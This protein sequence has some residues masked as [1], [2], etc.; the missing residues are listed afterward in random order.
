MTV[1]RFDPRR[2]F[3][4]ARALTLVAAGLLAAAAGGPAAPRAH[5]ADAAGTVTR[6]FAPTNTAL[7][8][9]AA[10][11][12]ARELVGQ[13]PLG[14]GVRVGLR[15]EGDDKLGADVQEALLQ[16]LNERRITCVLL[17]PSGEAGADA[18][19]E[20]AADPA[21]AGDA[22]TVSP[23]AGS[24]PNLS[25]LAR[26]RE[27]DAF[28]SLQAERERQ[29]ARADSAARAQ[30][31]GGGGAAAPDAG[32]AATSVPMPVLTW[33]VQEARV[34]YV[35]QFR[36]GL[37][38]SPRV[39]RR[40]RVDLALRLTPTGTDAIAWS[41]TADSTVGDVVH[42]VELAALEDRTRPETRPQLP[43]SSFKKVLEPAL[44]VVLIAGLVSL[45]YQ[46]R[47]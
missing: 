31:A 42:K 33:R 24:E 34:D 18:A 28:S 44:V 19:A 21:D 17:P 13:V 38:G 27:T 4:R 35:R 29:A 11:G 23:P 32:P 46:N 26:Q 20:A 9:R 12:A 5:A 47:P 3:I 14:T 30:A 25:D 8:A 40:A 1:Y 10:L 37:F 36:G 7:L 6:P 41:G 16:A 43:S 45:F 2:G 39:E 22:T 15:R